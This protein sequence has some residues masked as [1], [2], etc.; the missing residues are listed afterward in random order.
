MMKSHGHQ[1]QRDDRQTSF[2]YVD[3]LHNLYVRTY[4]FNL[5]IDFILL[6][7]YLFNR[8]LVFV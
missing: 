5:I 4:K 3:S 1:R 8:L 7:Q 2:D 6:N